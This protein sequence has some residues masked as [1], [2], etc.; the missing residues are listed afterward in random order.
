MSAREEMQQKDDEEQPQKPSNK[1]VK[2]DSQRQPQTSDKS[3][4]SHMYSLSAYH[5]LGQISILVVY[6]LYNKSLTYHYYTDNS[7]SC[8]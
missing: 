1:R 4:H 3:P 6:G 5:R 7:L 8:V 2:Y